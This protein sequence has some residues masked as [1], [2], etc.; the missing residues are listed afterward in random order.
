MQNKKRVNMPPHISA[1][2]ATQDTKDHI[3]K[4]ENISESVMNFRPTPYLF[5]LLALTLNQKPPSNPSINPPDES[6][7]PL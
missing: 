6:A 2:V 3:P 1:A 5:A 7:A 4:I